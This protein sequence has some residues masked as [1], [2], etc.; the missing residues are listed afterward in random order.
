MVKPP[1][2]VDLSRL[3][4][5]VVIV[6]AVVV[7]VVMGR[8]VAE[9]PKLTP[10]AGTNCTSVIHVDPVAIMLGDSY[11]GGWSVVKQ[12]DALGYATARKLGYAPN[13]AGAG[14]AGY[15][16]SRPKRL[17]PPR[18]GFAKQM[19]DLP[20]NAPWRS[21]T[22]A[23][24]VVLEGGLADIRLNPDRVYQAVITTIELAKQQ[25]PTA[26]IV[27]LGPANVYPNEKPDNIILKNQALQARAAAAEGVTFIPFDDL[28][29]HAEFMTYLSDDA[30]HPTADGA[31]IL[32][33]RFAAKLVELGIPD[34]SKDPD[35]QLVCS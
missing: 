4:G 15:L 8:W 22:P 2:R 30:T 11:F 20:I 21:A 18:G 10:I 29:P 3:P 24:L 34:H 26:R 23:S 5:I 35:S 33:D 19:V 32:I 12:Q 9:K 14:A 6:A 1:R 28:M 17:G 16:R 27:M 7:A 25:Q 31:K 13:I